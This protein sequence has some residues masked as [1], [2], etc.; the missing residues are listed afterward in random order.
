M[1]GVRVPKPATVVAAP[2]AEHV[3]VTCGADV[4]KAEAP[5]G[6][7]LRPVGWEH[8]LPAQAGSSPLFHLANTGKRMVVPDLKKPEGMAAL[9]RIPGL[10]EL[11]SHPDLADLTAIRRSGKAKRL[12]AKTEALIKTLPCVRREALFAANDIPSECLCHYSEVSH[13]PQALANDCFD[14]VSCPHGRTPAM[15]VPPIGFSDYGRRKTVPRI[16]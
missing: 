3:M 15:P 1:T 11:L 8:S 16:P 5:G 10:S 13:D 12:S 6:D 4:T 2:A 14:T 9:A 7:L